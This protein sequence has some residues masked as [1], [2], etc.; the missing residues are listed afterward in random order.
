MVKRDVYMQLASQDKEGSDRVLGEG[1]ANQ[2][3]QDGVGMAEKWRG[4]M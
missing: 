2:A 3:N 1:L 4:Y